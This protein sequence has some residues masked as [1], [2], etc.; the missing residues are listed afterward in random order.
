MNKFAQLLSSPGPFII[1]GG[2]ATE[3][4]KL[5]FDLDNDLWSASVLASDPDAIVK[6]HRSYL[7]AGADCIISASYQASRTGFMSHGMSEAE[8]DRLIVSTVELAT[9][10]RD[11]YLADNPGVDRQPAVAASIGPWGAAQHDGSEYT[12]AYDVSDQALGAFH[13]ER[14]KLLDAAGA[15]L[16]AV[17]TI[18]NFRE[19]EILAD[20]LDDVSTPAWVAFAC[21]DERHISDGSPLWAAAGLFAEHA[22]VLAVG[23]NCTPPQFVTPLISAL[24]SAAPDKAIV[25]YPNSGETYHTEDNSWSGTACDIHGD[26]DVAGWHAAGAK[27]IGGCCRTS[28]ADIATI[29]CRLKN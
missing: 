9:R 22:K 8:A 29:S 10:A 2:L 21:R 25:V 5:G 7:D 23:I 13:A 3:L 28:P 6:V 1:D 27:G 16:L 26:F 11:E 19:A 14:L 12:G 17:E 4:E 24:R 15:D 18:P 20:V